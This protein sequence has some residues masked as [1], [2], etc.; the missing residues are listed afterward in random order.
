MCSLD[1]ENI[2]KNKRKI[3]AEEEEQEFDKALEG[4]GGYLKE[5]GG[6]IL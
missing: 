3:E 4:S 2:T 6:Y 5:P 1:Y